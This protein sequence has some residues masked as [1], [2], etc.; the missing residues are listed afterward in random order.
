MCNTYSKTA[1]LISMTPT[2]AQY[3]NATAPVQGQYSSGA[4]QTQNFWMDLLHND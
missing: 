2:E 3:S 4:P 1:A